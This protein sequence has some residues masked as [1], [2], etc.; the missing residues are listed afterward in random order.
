MRIGCSRLKCESLLDPHTEPRTDWI[1]A[2]KNLEQSLA[3][4]SEEHCGVIVSILIP[5]W[6]LYVD[7]SAE[8]ARYGQN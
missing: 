8:A 7:R 1:L 2:S 6:L 3:A 4:V 5:L